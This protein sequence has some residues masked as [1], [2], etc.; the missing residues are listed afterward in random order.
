MPPFLAVF[1]ANARK[2]NQFY[3]HEILDC[4]C[5]A[6]RKQAGFPPD[7]EGAVETDGKAFRYCLC[8]S[9]EQGAISLTGDIRLGEASYR[10]ELRAHRVDGNLF[11]I[12][13]LVFDNKIQRLDNR[14][15]IRDVLEYIGQK[16]LMP[17]A[18]GEVPEPH[19]EK[20]RF[21]KIGRFLTRLVPDEPGIWHP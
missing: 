17:A 9:E 5:P 16:M 1:S 2:P 3:V 13:G 14:Q 21:G 12:S 10:T 6:P 19:K 7:T 20:G 4:L 11:E 8:A 18:Q 15:C